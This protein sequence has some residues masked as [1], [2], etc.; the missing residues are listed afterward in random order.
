MRRPAER[1]AQNLAAVICAAA[2]FL[3]MSSMTMAQS[4]GSGGV[5]EGVQGRVTFASG[6]PAANV[7]VQARS[8]GQM[9]VADIG[10]FTDK[11]G[12]FYWPLPP[13]RFELTFVHQ[14]RSLARRAVEVA[15]SG[16]TRVDIQLSARN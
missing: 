10:I 14:G 15:R 11:A 7:F 3:F 13:G 12:N 1:R 5:R 16:A 8:L 2:L 6:K 9:A 4:A